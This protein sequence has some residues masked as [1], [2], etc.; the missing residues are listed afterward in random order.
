MQEL[1]T[2]ATLFLCISV[3]R[4][5][6]RIEILEYPELEETHKDHQ[7]QLLAP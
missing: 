6:N 2:M 7:G 5:D 1:I 3:L 4:R